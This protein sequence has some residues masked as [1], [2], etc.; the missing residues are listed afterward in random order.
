MISIYKKCQLPFI[1]LNL[2]DK[3]IVIDVMHPESCFSPYFSWG[4]IHV[5]YS[6]PYVANSIASMLAGLTVSKD[7]DINTLL[8]KLKPTELPKRDISGYIQKGV[9]SDV[10][11]DKIEARLK[12]II[13]AYKW[14]LDYKVQDKIRTLRDYNRTHNIIFLDNSISI[15]IKDPCKSLSFAFLLKAYIEGLFPFQDVFEDKIIERC[16]TNC[17]RIYYTKKEIVR[18]PREIVPWKKL[19]NNI[20]PKIFD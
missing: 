11:L 9:Y 1:N 20:E 5:P 19:S 2:R 13:P 10:I 14:I 15:D 17:K 6:F 12:L 3:I 7:L 16:Y 4:D 18:V 8:F